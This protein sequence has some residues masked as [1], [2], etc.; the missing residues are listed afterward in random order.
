MGEDTGNGIEMIIAISGLAGTGKDTLGRLLAEELGIRHLCPTFKDL[1]AREGVDLM[2]FQ[3]KAARDP[4][5]DR[6]FD[7]MLKAEAARGPCVATSW[8]SPW[9]LDADVKIY[10]YASDDVRAKRL[11]ERD[12]MSVRKALE[13]LRRRDRQNRARYKKVYGIDIYDRSGFDVCLNSGR[14]TP[15]QLA[16]IV[17]GVVEEKKNNLKPEFRKPK[18]AR[19]KSDFRFRR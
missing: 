19:M 17:R 6:K 4:T 14:F 5:I 9:V 15:G 3:K 12:G 18:F 16:R 2:E 8:L 7:R 1:A 13:H 10:L 11:A